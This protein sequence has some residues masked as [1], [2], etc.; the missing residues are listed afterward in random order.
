MQQLPALMTHLPEAL[1]NHGCHLPQAAAHAQ[2]LGAAL[3]LA[4]EWQPSATAG[5]VA[6]LCKRSLVT[7]AAILPGYLPA[8][9][10]QM[11]G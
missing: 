4:L 6:V 10:L 3:A 5:H 1:K 11:A 8:C 7:H 2:L 9:P